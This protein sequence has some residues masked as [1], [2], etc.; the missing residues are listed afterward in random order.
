MPERLRGEYV[1]ISSPGGPDSQRKKSLLNPSASRTLAPVFNPTRSDPVEAANPGHV[2]RTF[3]KHIGQFR[4]KTPS[5]RSTARRREEIPRAG[6][7]CRTRAG[8][9]ERRASAPGATG[10]AKR[11]IASAPREVINNSRSPFRCASCGERGKR[12][13]DAQASIARNCVRRST[14]NDHR[15]AGRAPGRSALRPIRSVPPAH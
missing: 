5:G 7:T 2:D 1:Y 13:R 4:S 8:S 14:G 6:R 3:E 12:G 10:S 11:G 9:E 15:S